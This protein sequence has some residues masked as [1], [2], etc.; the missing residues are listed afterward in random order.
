MEKKIYAREHDLLKLCDEFRHV[1]DDA[2]KAI[3]IHYCPEELARIDREVYEQ[4]KKSPLWPALR[5]H[6]NLGFHQ[7]HKAHGCADYKNRAYDVTIDDLFLTLADTR[8]SAISRKLR[9]GVKNQG[10]FFYRTV[11]IWKEGREGQPTDKPQHDEIV[12]KLC[13]GE[14]PTQLYKSYLA[15][16]KGRAEDSFRFPF[17]SLDLHNRL[18]EKWYQFFSKNRRYFAPNP[19]TRFLSARAASSWL[20]D[21]TSRKGF[22]KK[23]WAPEDDG[24]LRKPIVFCRLKLRVNENLARIN[25]VTIIAKVPELLAELVEKGISHAEPLYDLGDELILVRA[26]Q[27][28]DKAEF[29]KEACILDRAKQ[30]IDADIAKFLGN[31]CYIKLPFFH[32]SMR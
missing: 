15:P 21:L 4:L 28:Y 17:S 32:I 10:G 16:M 23:Q 9:I 7:S 11:R 25:D 8:A 30:E 14:D 5:H 18:V 3:R 2:G 27:H 26:F 20:Y 13:A 31:F 22:R 19:P 6:C 24:R 1:V 29:Q 12:E